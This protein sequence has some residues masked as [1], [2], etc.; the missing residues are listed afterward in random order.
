MA[1]TDPAFNV[2]FPGGSIVGDEKTLEEGLHCWDM[3]P[4][5]CNVLPVQCGALQFVAGTH[6]FQ[7]GRTVSSLDAS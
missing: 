4:V 2:T 3:D 7:E 5:L 1:E 6:G